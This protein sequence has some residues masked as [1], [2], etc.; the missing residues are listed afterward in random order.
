VGATVLPLGAPAA[1]AAESPPNPAQLILA[2]QLPDGAIAQWVDR[3]RIDPYLANYAVMGLARASVATGNAR[4]LTAAWRWLAWYRDHMDAGGY[5]TDYT[6]GPGP[7]YVETST[8]DMDSTD[9]Y[10]GTFLIALRR[11]F[12]ASG[13]TARLRSFAGAATAAVRAIR[14]T[15]QPGGLTWATPDYHA[16]LLMDQAEAYAGLR[17]AAALAKPMGAPSLSSKAGPAADAIRQAVVGLWQA[18]GSAFAVARFEDGSVDPASWD[19]YYP[20]ATSQAWAVAVGNGLSP[21]RPLVP[22]ARARDLLSRF[23]SRWPQWDR[24]DAQAAFDNGSHEVEFWP[25]IGSALS[26]VGRASAGRQGTAAIVSWARDRSW[27]WPF[28]VG[29]AGEALLVSAG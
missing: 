10:A 20:D 29:A 6:V 28:S 13:D 22:A 16:A 25:M 2:S 3:N 1:A 8:G 26:A 11:T 14:S 23:A 9:G 19:T 18:D 4:Y 5:V 7:A 15:Q 27:R 12:A 24:P 21:N 17:A